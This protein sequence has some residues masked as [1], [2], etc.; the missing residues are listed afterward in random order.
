MN[1]FFTRNSFNIRTVPKIFLI[2][3]VLICLLVLLGWQFDINSLKS[4]FPIL[5]SMN[6]LT[7]WC[8]LLIVISFQLIITES[9]LEQ[10]YFISK[11]LSSVVFMICCTKLICLYY[12]LDF[13]IDAILFNEKIDADSHTRLSNSMSVNTAVGL[14]FLVL[15]L[16]FFHYKTERRW[17]LYQILTILVFYFGI[18]SLLCYSYNVP[19]FYDLLKYFPMSLLSAICFILI[20][21]SILL[22]RLDIGIVKEFSGSLAGSS[23]GTELLFSALVIPFLLG[24]VRIYLSKSNMFSTELSIA[25]L[26]LAVIII[27]CGIVLS[28][29]ILLNK[30]DLFRQKTEA[31]FQSLIESAPD[32]IVIIDGRKIIQLINIQ[33]ETMF[34][35]NRNAVLGTSI[36]LLI[37]QITQLEFFNEIGED[38]PFTKELTGVKNAGIQFP[39]EIR[40]SPLETEDEILTSISIRDIT[41]RKKLEEISWNNQ[42]IF[43]TLVTNVVDYAIFMLDID[44]NIV[45]WNKGAEIIKGYKKEEVEGKHI[46]LFYVEEDKNVPQQMLAEA[47]EKGKCEQEGWRVRKDGSIFWADVILTALHDQNGNITGYAKVTR[48]YTDKKK[49]QDALANFNEALSEQVHEKTKEIEQTT[50]QLRQL[51][52]HLQTAREEERKYIAREMHDELGQMIT[53]LR[54]DMIWLKKKIHTTDEVV[55]LRFERSLE[56]L[57]DIKQAIRRI[58]MDLHPAVLNDLGLI[59]ALKVYGKDFESRSGIK[60]TFDVELQDID[61][62][63][64]SSNICIGLYRIFQESLNNV[65]KHAEANEV[66]VCLQLNEQNLEFRILDNGQGFNLNEVV[67]KKSLGLVS[68]RERML[69]MDGKYQIQSS[70]GNGTVISLTVPIKF[71]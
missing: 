62:L 49:M 25:L 6:P 54:M 48:D 23:I 42:E 64:I 55:L 8:F 53:G 16:Q 40:I 58:A 20:S 38:F 2:I 33:T 37:P 12:N 9:K 45:T 31:K 18:F 28:S 69:M 3:I 43:R 11:A 46:S 29:V 60:T 13:K 26:V 41:Q 32:A 44:G 5:V 51:S 15:I 27:F 10:K 21:L 39:I 65:A 22:S 30:K 63:Q 66:N 59:T 24:F 70:P 71:K 4:V 35:L 67:Q 17:V 47:K 57:N 1:K 56:L 61:D 50:E 52:A 7:A 68:I 19:E 34:E 14:I 36:D